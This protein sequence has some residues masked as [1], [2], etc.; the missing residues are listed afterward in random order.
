MRPDPDNQVDNELHPM[1]V[2]I[3]LVFFCL[4]RLYTISVGCQGLKRLNNKYNTRSDSVSDLDICL[5]PLGSGPCQTW[6]FFKE[7]PGVGAVTALT[8]ELVSYMHLSIIHAT[9]SFSTKRYFF[10]IVKLWNSV[11]LIIRPL[12]VQ[13]FGLSVLQVPIYLIQGI[14]DF[15]IRKLDIMGI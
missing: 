9:Y 13:M 11:N 2:G 12:V 5:E 7:L 1:L 6:D 4:W 10:T 15:L 3:S 8:V 14:T